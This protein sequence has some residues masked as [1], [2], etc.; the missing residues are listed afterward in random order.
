M[1]WPMFPRSWFDFFFFS[2]LLGEDSHFDHYF[3][4]G[5][6]PPTSHWDHDSMIPSSRPRAPESGW[7]EDDF[8]FGFRPIFRGFCCYSFR[9]EIGW[10][11]LF[12]IG[13]TMD[14]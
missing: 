12:L 5:S 4:T 13:R 2:P 9:E 10:C 6:K 7:L 14:G 8:P 3:S 11:C 1:F